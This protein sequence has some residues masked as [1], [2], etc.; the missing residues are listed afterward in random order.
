VSGPQNGTD[1]VFLHTTVDDCDYFQ[2]I[3]AWD[4]EVALAKQN[5]ELRA[6]TSSFHSEK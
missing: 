2:Q 1:L 3:L 5:A 4:A 6:V